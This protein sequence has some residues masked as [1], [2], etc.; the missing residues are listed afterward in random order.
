MSNRKTA[1]VTGASGFIAKHIVCQLLDAGWAV[2]GS[3]RSRAKADATRHTIAAHV[4][5]PEALD[6]TLSFVELDLTSDAG[7]DSAMTGSDALIHTA[8]P[9]PLDQ[10]KD[11]DELIGPAV[12]GTKRAL[13]AA[14]AAGL[15]R[16]V[17]TSSIVAIMFGPGSAR[18]GELTE[19]DWTDPRDARANAYARSKT[20]AERAAWAMAGEDPP[21]ALTVINPGFVMGAALDSDTGTTYEVIERL[22]AGKDPALPDISFP[23]VHVADVAR[24]H[25]TALDQE[26]SIGRRFILADRTLTFQEL[27]HAL[28]SEYPDRRISTRLAPRWLLRVLALFDPAIKS[29]LPQLGD[30]P[31]LSNAA[32]RDVLKMAFHPAEEA[33][34]ETA[35]DILARA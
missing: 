10:P 30:H 34:R 26:E 22:L 17:L 11:P 9:F 33:L 8:S 4:Q 23:C 27:A 5:N 24:A 31:H 3:T 7:W 2:R 21:L 28:K 29:I 35:A 19:A 18:G 16:V 32:A 13:A 25:V 20:L 6:E 14:R 12:E 15:S 1:F